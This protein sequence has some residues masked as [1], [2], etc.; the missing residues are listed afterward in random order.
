M[1]SNCDI[2]YRITSSITYDSIVS[3]LLISL[4][5]DIIDFVLDIIEAGIVTA[6]FT[7]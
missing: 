7:G 4:F 3:I 6:A 1:N 5:F 2:T